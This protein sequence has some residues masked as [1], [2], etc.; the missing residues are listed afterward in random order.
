MRSSSIQIRMIIPAILLVLVLA[1]PALAETVTPGD[2]NNTSPG[3][4]MTTGDAGGLADS[5]W[6]K[7]GGPDLNNTGQ[8][9]F[10][11]AQTN[12]TK[13][14]YTAGGAFQSGTPVIG[15][16]GTVY[17]GNDDKNVYAF[18][19]DGTVKW[20]YPAGGSFMSP[21]AVGADGTI[22]IGNYD[23]NILHKNEVHVNV[24]NEA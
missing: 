18:N 13:W 6:P 20:T 8:S 16:D 7:F 5:A 17:I 19:P 23:S 15:S 22:Y 4:V 14:V 2:I 24:L 3:F 21:P 11:G 12:A 1:V 10:V 9:L